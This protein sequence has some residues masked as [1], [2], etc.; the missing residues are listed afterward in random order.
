MSEP[1]DHITLED[2]YRVYNSMTAMYKHE[3]L[4]ATGHGK[5]ILP[6]DDLSHHCKTHHFIEGDSIGYFRLTQNARGV[7]DIEMQTRSQP[8]ISLVDSP[9]SW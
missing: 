3:K 5:G 9:A 6:G 2:Y 4:A 8:L 7:V 1:H